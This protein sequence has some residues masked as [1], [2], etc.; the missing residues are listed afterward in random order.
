MKTQIPTLLAASVLLAGT[1]AA[2]AG[3]TTIYGSRPAKTVS[4][5]DAATNACFEAFIKQLIPNSNVRVRTV[6]LATNQV[7]DSSSLVNQMDVTMS[8]RSSITG[9]ELANSRCTV[10][11]RA[12]VVSLYTHVTQPAG[13]AGLTPRDIK[14]AQT[15]G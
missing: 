4:R 10:T 3:D 14:L 9:K 6:S 8:A 15:G 2:V 11:N 5:E 13:L 12:K 7:F 1:L